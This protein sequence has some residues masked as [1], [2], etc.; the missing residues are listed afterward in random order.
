MDVGV[1]SEACASVPQLVRHPCA[2]WQ[3]GAC[4]VSVNSPSEWRTA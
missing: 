1:P 3:T 2:E 4:H